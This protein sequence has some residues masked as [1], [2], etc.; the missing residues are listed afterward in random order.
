[1]S[2]EQD[3]YVLGEAYPSRY[4]RETSP[5]WLSAVATALGARSPG[6]DGSFSYLE[7]GCGSALGAAIHAAAWP[8]ARFI[9]VDAHSGHM[10]HARALG[11]AAGLTGLEARHLTFAELAAAPDDALPPCDFIVLHGVYAWIAP[12]N[13]RAI[14]RIVARWLKPGGLLYVSYMSQPGAA[15][16][17]GAQRLMFLS[18]QGADTPG[19]GALRGLERLR[20]LR[21]GGAGYFSTHPELG[22]QLDHMARETPAYLAHEFL[23]QTWEPLHVGQVMRDFAAAGCRYLGSATPLENIDSVSIPAALQSLIQAETDREMAETLR[24]LARNQSLRRDIY[25][26]AG[27]TLPAAPTL[28]P[29]EHRAALF[30]QAIAVLPGAPTDGPLRFDTRIGPVDGPRELFGPLLQALARGPQSYGGLAARP[31]YAQRPGV[32]NQLFQMLYWAGCAHPLRTTPIDIRA[33]LALN[34][35]LSATEESHDAA[36]CL[37]APVLGSALPVSAL[38]R[39]CAAVLLAHPALAG[40]ALRQAARQRHTATGRSWP[41]DGEQQVTKFEHRVLP[42]WRQ[43]GVVARPA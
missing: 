21:D 42:L 25:Q 1:M 20:A 34:R 24:D 36:A 41:S 13:R 7:L 29:D 2:N 43:Y 30:E 4:H 15:P 26:R 11:A 28:S 38:E 6:L 39:S 27:D 16:L 37:A 8:A 17:A 35:V 3:G 23:G 32:L 40:A 18:G 9:G 12:D 10:A 19:A 14:A 31:A 33:A 22:R 5:L